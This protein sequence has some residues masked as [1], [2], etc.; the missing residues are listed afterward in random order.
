[1]AIRVRTTISVPPDLKARMDAHSEGV[2]WSA[3]ACRAFETKLAEII[4]TNEQDANMQDV[5]ERLRASKL[6]FEVLKEM[7][8]ESQIVDARRRGEQWAKEVPT[9][10]LLHRL[11]K[12]FEMLYTLPEVDDM[13]TYAGSVVLEGF[14]KGVFAAMHR[15]MPEDQVEGKSEIFWMTYLENWSGD[16]PPTYI[17][18]F[19][20]GAMDV[21]D[22]VKDKL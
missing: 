9:C 3:I 17:K 18:A 4:T 14:G 11:S 19:C 21:W 1:M 5:I 10:I 20:E 8:T 13:E 7:E 6:E 12:H 16:I 15:E 2:N 22:Q